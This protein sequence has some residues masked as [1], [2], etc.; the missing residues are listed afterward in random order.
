MN[1]TLANLA[2]I[3]TIISHILVLWLTEGHSQRIGWYRRKRRIVF[4]RGER[5]LVVAISFSFG[6]FVMASLAEE[7]TGAWLLLGI[8]VAFSFYKLIRWQVSL[9]RM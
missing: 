9:K 8:F 6:S 1:S 4:S 3:M 5:I 7:I 2:A